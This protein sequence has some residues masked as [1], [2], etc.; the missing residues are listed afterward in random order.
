MRQHENVFPET[1]DEICGF[2]CEA[3]ETNHF[4]LYF[5][6]AVFENEHLKYIVLWY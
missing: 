2:K 1:N 6:F 4:F 3:F 5:F